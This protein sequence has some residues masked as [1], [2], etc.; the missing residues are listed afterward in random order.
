VL[1]VRELAGADREWATAFLRDSWGG[2]VA[3]R[4]ELVELTAL[5]GFVASADGERAGLAT[6]AV[7]GDECE[8]VTIDSLR[9]GIGIGRML[10]EAVHAAAVEAKCRRL[11]LVT[12]NDN[13]RALE[14]YQR[15]G[16]ELVAFRRDAVTEA[17]KTLKPSIPERAANGIPIKDELEL[18]LLL[19]H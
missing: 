3:R 5:P 10:L 15:W 11:W 19:D 4:G 14:L 18:E 7:R 6:Y 13:V 12:T 2:G 8:L 9:E 16:M 17:R 1:E